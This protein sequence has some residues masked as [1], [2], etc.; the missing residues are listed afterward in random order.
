MHIGKTVYKVEKGIAILGQVTSLNTDS[1]T[2][3]S[4]DGTEYTALKGEAHGTDKLH[5]LISEGSF[6]EVSGHFGVGSVVADKKTGVMT[7]VTNS[8][9]SGAV[10][11]ASGFMSE[12]PAEKFTY[13]GT[14]KPSYK[15]EEDGDVEAD[16]EDEDFDDD[17]EDVEDDEEHEA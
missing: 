17:D 4:A 16:D 14:I 3:T 1:L 7:Q 13:I 10:T 8:D 5:H 11:T 2:F 9:I 6:V 12:N 15:V